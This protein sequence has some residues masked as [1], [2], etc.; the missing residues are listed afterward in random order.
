MAITIDQLIDYFWL[1]FDK[2][3]SPADYVRL[4]AKVEIYTLELFSASDNV[5]DSIHLDSSP[6]LAM[7]SE[8]ER[9]CPKAVELL[10]TKSEIIAYSLSI[11]NSYTLEQRIQLRSVFLKRDDKKIVYFHERRKDK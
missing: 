3:E 10:A 11:I 4:L 8:I 6:F 9:V 7:A 5:D 1:H 2:A